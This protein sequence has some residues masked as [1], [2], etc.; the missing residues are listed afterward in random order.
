[1]EN[2]ASFRINTEKAKAVRLKWPDSF[3]PK[4]W[5]AEPISKLYSFEMGFTLS[6]GSWGPRLNTP[7][8]KLVFENAFRLQ[9]PR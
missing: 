3:S 2:F 9:S 4:L 5:Q 7:K 6:H 1:M 8:V